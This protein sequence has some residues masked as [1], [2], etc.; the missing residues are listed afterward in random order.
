MYLLG[1]CLGMPDLQSLTQGRA[2]YTTQF[3]KYHE[4]PNSIADII[5]KPKNGN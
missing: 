3:A 2:S 4:L 5:I 1:K